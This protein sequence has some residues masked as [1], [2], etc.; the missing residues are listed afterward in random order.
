MAHSDQPN[1]PG[2]LHE[3]LS[4]T[5]DELSALSGV[6]I[7]LI[8]EMVDHAILEPR[9]AH[10]RDW[11]FPAPAL[12]R[13]RRA[14]RLRRDLDLNWPGVC[15]AIDLLEQIAELK[16]RQRALLRRLG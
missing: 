7:R 8:V 2:L 9:G 12:P 1:N 11:H 4:L 14:L 3:E 10:I 6:E 13:V 16:R 15:L 5:L